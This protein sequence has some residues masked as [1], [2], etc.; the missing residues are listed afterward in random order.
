M[1]IKDNTNWETTPCIWIEDG[2]IEINIEK[3]TVEIEWNF[4][5]AWEGG[6]GRMEIERTKLNEL[7]SKMDDV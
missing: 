7:L 3:E 2:D 6:S 5:G 1:K 4:D